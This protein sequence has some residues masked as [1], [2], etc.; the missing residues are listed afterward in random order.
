MNKTLLVA[1]LALFAVIT[2][3][4]CSPGSDGSAELAYSSPAQTVDYYGQWTV[5]GESG[6]QSKVKVGDNAFVFDNMPFAGIAK[7]LFPNQP[8]VVE[9]PSGYIVP[10]TGMAYTD[11]TVVYTLTPSN[12]TFEAIVGGTL[13]HIDISFM[14]AYNGTN[15]S[16]GTLSR[17][18][19]VYTI[20]LWA[21][22]ATV[23]DTVTGQKT[24]HDISVKIQFTTTKRVK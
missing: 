20:V 8:T 5:N 12:W 6:T 21:T 17:Q 15:G 2:F 18:S 13:K 22:A 3:A 19:G 24:S 9:N 11:R 14:S 1:L 10:Y 23:T 4:A 7:C 16:W